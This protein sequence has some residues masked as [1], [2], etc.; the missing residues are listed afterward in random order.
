VLL[1]YVSL[2]AHIRH[3]IMLSLFS[4]FLAVGGPSRSGEFYTFQVQATC[5][6][7]DQNASSIF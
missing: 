4:A 3:R 5:F 1:T 7:I 2:I 6:L